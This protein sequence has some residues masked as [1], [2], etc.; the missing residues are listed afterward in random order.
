M[1]GELRQHHQ[2]L[3]QNCGTVTQQVGQTLWQN[4]NARFPYL[5]D[6][7]LFHAVAKRGRADEI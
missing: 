7:I 5:Q 6:L 4:E 2:V 3:W 1:Q